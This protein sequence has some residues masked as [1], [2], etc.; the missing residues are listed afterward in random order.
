M[1]EINVDAIEPKENCIFKRHDY[2][3]KRKGGNCY[4]SAVYIGNLSTKE[5]IKKNVATVAYKYPDRQFV[6][7]HDGI[8]RFTVTCDGQLIYQGDHYDVERM[9]QEGPS[10]F[11][12]L[13][14]DVI[15]QII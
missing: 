5:L 8:I 9:F 2:K 14:K 10:V 7:E 4:A 6:I 12:D 13:L 3:K 1:R 15:Q 11:E